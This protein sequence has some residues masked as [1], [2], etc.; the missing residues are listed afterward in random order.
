MRASEGTEMGD[1]MRRMRRLSMALE[2]ALGL[3]RRGFFIP[4]R[5]ACATPAPPDAPG[6][7]AAAALFAQ[8]EPD[9]AETLAAIEACGGRLAALDGPA[10]EPRWGQSW[11]PRLD[12]AAAYALV[13]TRRPRRIVEVGSGHSTRFLAR[14]ARDVGAGTEILCL[15]PA[16][17]APLP[18]EVAHRAELL[19][20]EHADLFAALA[21]GDVAFFDSSHV[22]FP[23]T[24][25]DLILTRILPALA[26]GVLVHVHDV[27]LPNPYPESWSWRGYGEQSGVAAW[28]LAGGLR[29]VFSSRWALTRMGAAARPAIAALPLPEDAVES[30][31]WAEKTAPA[32]GPAIDPAINPGRP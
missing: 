30:S 2:T 5:H 19:A 18:P 13:A 31:F 32:I 9:F 8:A 27:F 11:F 10:P 23:H 15:D 3:R 22:L 14:A 28:L 4:Y 17:R 16:P 24:D 26:P 21:P 29:P 12:G 20:P 1:R 7:P 6:Y 25:V